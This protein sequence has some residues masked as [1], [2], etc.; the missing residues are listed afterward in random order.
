MVERGG[1]TTPKKHRQIRVI[2]FIRYKDKIWQKC[3]LRYIKDV[4][5]R[6]YQNLWWKGVVRPAR[7]KHPEYQCYWVHKVPA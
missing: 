1:Q 5:E 2:G 4:F 3:R 7:I 6:T